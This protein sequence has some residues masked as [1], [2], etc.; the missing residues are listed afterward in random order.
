MLGLFSITAS[1]TGS[2]WGFESSGLVSV[3]GV[4]GF[5]VGSGGGGGMFAGGRGGGLGMLTEGGGACASCSAAR[6]AAR[7]ACI[8]DRSIFAR[9]GTIGDASPISYKMFYVSWITDVSSFEFLCSILLTSPKFFSELELVF[10]PARFE[11][12]RFMSLLC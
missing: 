5:H 9:T 3:L 7:R 4:A 12:R 2:D 6:F 11:A 1:C 8:A 10:A